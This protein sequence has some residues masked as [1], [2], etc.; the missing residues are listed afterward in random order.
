M[1]SVVEPGRVQ[2][3]VD[4]YVAAFESLKD[5]RPAGPRWLEAIRQAAID[6]FAELGIP[7]T[8]DEEYR[9]TNVGPIAATPFE[10][11]GDVQVDLSAVGPYLFGTQAAAE[12]LFVNGRAG[13]ESGTVPLSFRGGQLSPKASPLRRSAPS[14]RLAAS[15]SSSHTSRESPISNA[16]LSAR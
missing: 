14:S 10:R 12:L 8:K 11:S 13:T 2:T 9:F 4:R 6:R 15:P 5:R 3:S 1:S 16:P 7:T